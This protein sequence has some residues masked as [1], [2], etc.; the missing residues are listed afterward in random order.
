[1]KCI[2]RAFEEHLRAAHATRDALAGE[3]A[4]AGNLLVE[5]YRSGGKAILFGN[6]GSASDALH[7]EGELL[8]RFRKDRVGLPA[9][10]LGGGVSAITAV[11]NDYG[12]DQVFARLAR[13]HIRP[14]DVALVFSTSGD[15]PG[16]VEAA[17][18]AKAASA[19]VIG[20]TGRSGGAL[21]DQVDVLLNVPSNDTPRI[22]EMHIVLGHI[23]CEIVEDALF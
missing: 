2:E 16:I 14:G 10:A 19:R 22:Q 13:A 9:I 4:R 15:S 3:L 21:R 8:G 17:I 6:G 12:Y 20:F 1:M 7:I 11:A 5:A 23:L 18:A